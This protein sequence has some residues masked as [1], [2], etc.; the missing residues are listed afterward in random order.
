MQEVWRNGDRLAT[1]AMSIERNG[2]EHWAAGLY[3]RNGELS[4]RVRPNAVGAASEV[5]GSSVT[6]ASIAYAIPY[7]CE[8]CFYTCGA[9]ATGQIPA[10]LGACV[11]IG[12]NFPGPW[13]AK[14]GVG[15]AC[16][17]VVAAKEIITVLEGCPFFCETVRLC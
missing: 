17:T 13:F 8:L 1:I 7:G 10:E 15:V 16:V 9:I 2:S 14:V 11:S 5:D 4:R 6:D 3:G 12:G